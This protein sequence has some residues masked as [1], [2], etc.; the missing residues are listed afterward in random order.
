MFL[1]MAMLVESQVSWVLKDRATWSL[2]GTQT[3]V[4][5]RYHP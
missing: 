3:F 2:S 1:D 5:S 4:F